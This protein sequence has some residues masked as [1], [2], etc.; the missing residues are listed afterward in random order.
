MRF[1]I[2]PGLTAVTPVTG[3]ILDAALWVALSG[4]AAGVP[5]GVAL[6]IAWQAAR[7]RVVVSRARRSVPE[8][9]KVAM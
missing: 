4:L 2:D 7:V 6:H 3:G 1:P 5:L 9:R 8:A